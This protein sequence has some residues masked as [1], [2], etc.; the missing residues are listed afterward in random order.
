MQYCIL[1]NSGIKQIFDIR[2][3][4]FKLMDNQR[5]TILDELT[6]VCE[7]RNKFFRYE[8]NME[9][10]VEKQQKILERLINTKY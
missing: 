10:F 8:H 2:K 4:I 3:K 9:H 7:T 6:L 1:E 5:I